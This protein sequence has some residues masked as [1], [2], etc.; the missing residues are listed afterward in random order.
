[1]RT[2]YEKSNGLAGKHRYLIQSEIKN[3]EPL[4]EEVII[5]I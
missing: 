1:M 5:K 4:I 3:I 2:E